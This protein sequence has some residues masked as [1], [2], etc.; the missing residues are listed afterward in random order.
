[1]VAVMPIGREI[2]RFDETVCGGLELRRRE[3]FRKSCVMDRKR[4]VGDQTWVGETDGFRQFD[5]V[6]P[7]EGASKAFAVGA[8]ILHRFMGND[9]IGVNV[10]EIH[11]AARLEKAVS[12]SKNRFFILA[13]INNAIRDDDVERLIFEIES[14]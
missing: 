14:F 9:A 10:R 1:M 2:G 12:R 11:F 5:E 8:G 7:I 13:Q 6:S 3:Q 4:P